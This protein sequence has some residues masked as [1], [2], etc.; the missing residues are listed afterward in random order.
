VNKSFIAAMSL[1]A[2]SAAVF[3]A[4]EIREGKWEY[5][6]NMKMEGMPE[7]PKLPEGVKLPPGVTMPVMGGPNGINTTFQSCVTKDKPVP[8]QERGKQHCEQ[9]RMDR[10]GN[11]VNY[12]VRCTDDTGGV[13]DGEGTATYSGDAMT[14]SMHMKGTSHGHPIDMTQSMTGKYLGPCNG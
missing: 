13:I 14:S 1:C 9:T 6:V 4:D 12:A 5:N 7:M 2:V 11:T 3:A 10:S 8:Q